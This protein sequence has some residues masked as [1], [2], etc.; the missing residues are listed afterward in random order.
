MTRQGVGFCYFQYPH[1]C[2][3]FTR[4][5]KPTHRPLIESGY[6]ARHKKELPVMVRYITKDAFEA[7]TGET[8]PVAKYLDIILYSKEQLIEEAANIGNPAPTYSQEWAVISVKPQ[9]RNSHLFTSFTPNQLKRLILSKFARTFP[10]SC[11]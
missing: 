6:E 8:L 7:A 11:R 10:M 2:D 4:T 9:V 1:A 5:F 3:W